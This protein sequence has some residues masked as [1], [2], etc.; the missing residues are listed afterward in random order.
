MH[1]SRMSQARARRGRF[2][3]AAAICLVTWRCAAVS[4]SPRTWQPITL[5]GGQFPALCGVAANRLE[6][7]AI[8]GGAPGPIPF[9]VDEVLADGRYALPSGPRPTP[10]RSPDVLDSRDE[11]V[12]MVSD[13]GDR[14]TE[15]AAL[16]SGAFEIELHDPLGGPDRYAYLAAADHPRINPAKYVE[17]E[18]ARDVIET[19]H[20]RL[21][22][23]NGIPI[24]YA[25]QSRMHSAAPNVLDRFK[26]RVSARVLKL[27]NFRVNEDAVENGLLAWRAG[28]I[29]IIRRLSHSVHVILGIRAPQVTNSDFF[30]RDSVENPFRIRFPWVPRLLFGD[31]RVRMDLD[32]TDLDGYA[33]AWSGT[34]GAPLPIAQA[35]ASLKGEPPHAEWIALNGAGRVVIQMIAPASDLALLDR[36]LY[37]HDD[38]ATP[39]PPER[40]RGEHPGIGYAITGWENLSAGEHRLTSM[41][42]TA[43]D[44]YDAGVL[45]REYQRP[46]AITVR[47]ASVHR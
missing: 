19:E 40:V 28:P 2:A 25:V 6:V 20:Y 21:G 33:L 41:L 5:K 12:M 8:H 45:M 42:L 26:I 9:Q 32:F 4:A 13:F 27:F 35:A 47:P 14:A 18:P 39:D 10:E 30:Y 23:R 16:A 36:R 37:F 44:R 3:L 7:I 34:S 29:R 15:P 24:D 31:I 22:L 1:L 38:P 11:I 17:Y 43:E 46:P